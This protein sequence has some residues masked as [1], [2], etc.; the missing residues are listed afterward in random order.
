MR[1]NE[2]Q[3]KYKLLFWKT[4][5]QLGDESQVTKNFSV[6]AIPVSEAGI[7]IVKTM[8]NRFLSEDSIKKE[9][10]S[11][12]T[13][14]NKEA[15]LVNAFKINKMGIWN[16][17]RAI[18]LSDFIPVRASFDFQSTFKSFQRVRLFCVLKEDNS[19]VDFLDWQKEPI[20][21]SV[22]RP[23]Q[24]A[25]VLPSGNIAY[26]DFDQIRQRL[27]QGSNEVVFT[28]KE[29]TAQDYFSYLSTF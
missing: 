13:R 3:S 26:V 25:A 10:E 29:R 2:K 5:N 20:F 27:A 19:V 8:R 6:Y 4:M 18:K 12:I 15:D 28:T 7:D 17:D 9:V 14:I 16:I 24:I 22:E 11:E 1:V 23:M 21:L